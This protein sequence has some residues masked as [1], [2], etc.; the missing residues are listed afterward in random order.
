[1]V[2]NFL[3]STTENLMFGGAGGAD[4]P[5]IASDIEVRNNY[6]YKPERWAAPGVTLPPA[7]Q[8]SEKNS[9]EF[10]SARRA[11]VSGNVF[12]NTWFAAQWGFAVVL[13]VRTSDSGNIAVV[14][15]ITI[16]NNVLTNVGSGFNSLAHDD[17]CKLPQAPLCNKA[18]EARRWKISNNLIQLRSAHAPG[19]LRPQAF[20]VASGLAD[21]EFRHNTVVP[22]AGASCFAS[23][24]FR[25]DNGQK[26]PLAESGTRNLWIRDNLLCLPP[27]GD[28]GGQGS[29]GLQSYMGNPP[30]L[31][32]RFAGNVIFVPKEAQPASFPG[33]NRLTTSGIQFANP[34]AGDYTLVLPKWNETTDGKPAGVDAKALSVAISGAVDGH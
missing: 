21:V 27:T 26:W 5:Y 7:P 18:G 17:Q 2:N 12:E 28:Y 19:G 30:P 14:D 4:N 20:S 29:A 33:S 8:W 1:V 3:S 11:I 32:K 31:E 9:L 15:D 25:V 22:A 24:Y 13:T 10:K 16:E 23:I 34:A 6:F